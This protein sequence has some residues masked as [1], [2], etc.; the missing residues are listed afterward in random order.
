MSSAKWRPF[1]LGLNVLM[2][3]NHNTCNSGGRKHTSKWVW[4]CLQNSSHFVLASIWTGFLSFARSKLRLCSAN[5]R[6]GYWSNLPCDWPSTAWA[7]SRERDRK[8]AL[9]SQSCE[10]WGR[11]KIT[12]EFLR[13]FVWNF[14]GTLWNSTQNILPI[15]RKMWILFVS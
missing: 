4:Q 2:N 6:L 8:R 15:H 9:F 12:W 5:H 7:Y 13:Y 1:C 3:R 14:K 10:F 11:F